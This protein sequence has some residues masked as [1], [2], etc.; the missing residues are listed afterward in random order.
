MNIINAIFYAET[1]EFT[2]KLFLLLL[3]LAHQP[4]EYIL[5][6]LWN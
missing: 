6:C 1:V 5:Y 4:D 3:C 2:F